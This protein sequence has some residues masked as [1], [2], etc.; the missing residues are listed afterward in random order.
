VDINTLADAIVD[1][2]VGLNGNAKIRVKKIFT[3]DPPT[4]KADRELLVRAVCDLLTSSYLSLGNSGSLV[5]T[6]TA[7]SEAVELRVYEP[8]S[9]VCL[10]ALKRG[11]S[12]VDLGDSEKI[13]QDL[14]LARCQEIIGSHGGSFTAD[15]DVR[16]GLNFAVR[17]PRA[18]E[19]S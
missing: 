3:A 16:E 5:F 12:S 17:L 11:M 7:T 18:G 19:R 14:M 15:C 1:A 13:G 4:V 10:D 6:T 9:Q 8:G 2:F